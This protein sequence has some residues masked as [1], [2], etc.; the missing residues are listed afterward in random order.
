MVI[1]QWKQ[2]F[3]TEQ[4]LSGHELFPL[5]VVIEKYNDRYSAI[6]KQIATTHPELVVTMYAGFPCIVREKK[7]ADHYRFTV[8]VHKRKVRGQNEN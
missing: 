4:V 1:S 3:V 5:M 2:E 6:R 8:L 7:V